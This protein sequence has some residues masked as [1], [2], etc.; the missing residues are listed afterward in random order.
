MPRP[1]GDAEAKAIDG[2]AGLHTFNTYVSQFHTPHPGNSHEN[3]RIRSWIA[4]LLGDFQSQAQTNH[5]HMEVIANDTAKTG[6]QIN[7]FTDNEYWFCDSRNVLAKIHGSDPEFGEQTILLNAHFDSVPTSNGVTDNGISVAVLL[8]LVRYYVQH[9]PKH[10]ILF[11]F[12]NLEEGGLIGAETMATHPW[13]NP[14]KAFINLE[15]AGAGGRALLFRSN[16]HFG[17]KQLASSGVS[18]VHGSPMGNDML[19]RGWLRSDT[20][21]SVFSKHQVPGMDI[22]FY[23][24]RSHYHTPRDSIAYIK[25]SAVQYMGDVALHAVRSMDQAGAWPEVEDDPVIY[26]DIL[27]RIMITLSFPAFQFY[28]ILVLVTAPLVCLYMV[29]REHPD[30]RQALRIFTKD[31][32]R[33]LLLVLFILLATILGLVLGSTLLLTLYPLVTYSNAGLVVF[34][35]FFTAWCSMLGML[36]VLR[37][38]PWTSA[39]LKEKPDILLCGMNGLWWLFLVMATWSGSQGL[40]ALYFAIYFAVFGTLASVIYHSMDASSKARMPL[41]F[42]VQFLLPYILMVQLITMSMISLRHSTVD[43]SPEATVYG[44][45]ALPILLI[46]M[47]MLFWVQ[48]AGHLGILL[49]KSVLILGVV[50]LACMLAHRFDD[51]MSPNKISFHEQYNASAPTSQVTLRTAYG[52]DTIRSILDADELATFHCNTDN[53][54]LAECK[55]NTTRRPVYATLA[56][57]KEYTFDMTKSCDNDTCTVRGSYSVQHS[58]ICRIHLEEHF[59]QVQSAWINDGPKLTNTTVQALISYTDGF[60]KPVPWGF[61]YPASAPPPLGQFSCFYDEWVNG[62]LPSFLALHNGM[63]MDTVLLVRGEGLSLVHYQ[64]LTF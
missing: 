13:F 11:L 46:V 60:G 43:G 34:Y 5:I 53:D 48:K 19:K 22:A 36:L 25:P 21:Y 51:G 10:T 1:L 42:S 40:S 30:V 32:C 38:Q 24:P 33:G 37:S 27:G 7:W 52:V 15:G 56:P 28:N 35:L 44:F 3:G 41:M 50:L 20:D 6:V 18:F 64:S 39:W 59:D 55:Y 57:E 29:Y 9:P 12:N 16:Y 31:T 14:V 47:S 26:Y 17:V 58:L 8:E 49:D 54:G 62:E 45:F 63:P 23:G 61:T 4:S 2:F